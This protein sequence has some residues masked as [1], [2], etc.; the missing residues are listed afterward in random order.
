MKKPVENIAF[1]SKKLCCIDTILERSFAKKL[2]WMNN[3]VYPGSGH[4]VKSLDLSIPKFR[5]LGSEQRFSLCSEN[6]YLS[7]IRMKIFAPNKS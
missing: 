5:K 7:M 3:T 6:V 1:K 4:K 2:L